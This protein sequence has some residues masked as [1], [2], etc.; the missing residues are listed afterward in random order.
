MSR[1]IFLCSVLALGSL[2]GLAAMAQVPEPAP[3]PLQAPGSAAV[4]PVPVP[5]PRPTFTWQD[6]AGGLALIVTSISG[7]IAAAKQATKVAP[8]ND[9]QSETL[10]SINERTKYIAYEQRR[11]KKVINGH[12]NALKAL[13]VRLGLNG[14][15]ATAS[16]AEKAGLRKQI[17]ELMDLDTENED[18]TDESEPPQDNR[19]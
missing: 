14:H 7:S 17:R 6:L 18:D 13:Y 4:I 8:L 1:A 2:G 3:A 19:R 11:M 5:V 10:G 15:A 12:G 16:E 9:E